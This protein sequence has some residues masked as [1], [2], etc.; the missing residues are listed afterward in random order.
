MSNFDFSRQF[1]KLTVD[2]IMA[3]ISAVAPFLLLFLA[4]GTF[5]GVGIFQA[6][7]Y[8]HIFTPRFAANAATMAVFVS[9]LHQAI[10]FGLLVASMRDF[11]DNKPWN[12]WLGLIG[13]VALVWYDMKVAGWL[14]QVWASDGMAEAATYKSTVVFLILLGLL[15]E[16]RLI[17]TVDGASFGKPGNRRATVGNGQPAESQTQYHYSTNGNGR[18]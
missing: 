5:I 13:S 9:V 10:R 7:Y 18:H 8:R 2:G 16:C 15:L 17:L 12:G 14:A 6:D 1:G 3:A 4:I 11:S